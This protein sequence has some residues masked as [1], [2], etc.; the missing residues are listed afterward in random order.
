MTDRVVS[1]TSAPGSVA[2]VAPASGASTT[3]TGKN[4]GAANVIATSETKADTANIKVILAA[5][6]VTISPPTAT[7]S[8]T[9]TKTVQLTATAKNGGTTI[10]GRTITW[11]SSAPAVA[12]VNATTGLVTAVGVGTAQITAHI[13]LDG[14]NSAAPATITVTP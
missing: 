3:V 13:V 2:T 14:V 6:S 8:L 11:S 1:W 10:T 12:S 7:L 5:T 9:T 4:V